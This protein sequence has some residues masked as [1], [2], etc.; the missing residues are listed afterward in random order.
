M[1]RS[2]VELRFGKRGGQTPQ[3]SGNELTVEAVLEVWDLP[4]RETIQ[5]TFEE[6]RAHRA[7]LE[8]FVDELLDEI[9]K[10]TQSVAGRERELAENQR[11]IEARQ[12]ELAQQRQENELIRQALQGQDA[13]LAALLEKFEAVRGELNDAR[14]KQ[15]AN[16]DSQ[17]EALL[18]RLQ[19]ERDDLKQ[20]LDV[21]RDELA[22]RADVTETLTAT[23]SE[24]A[25][26]RAE[27]IQ[28]QHELESARNS[29]SSRIELEQERVALETELEMVRR[30][31][32][33]LTETMAEQKD[34]F[35][36][37]QAAWSAEL[38]K[39]R[40]LLETQSTMLARGMSDSKL[41]AAS[42]VQ[43]AS[44]G[45]GKSQ[46]SGEADSPVVD[47]IMAQFAKLQ[48]DVSERRKRKN[49]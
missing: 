2:S 11:Q 33:D 29:D 18:A 3:T 31:A 13:H 10:L 41:P 22:R 8:D 20:R 34:Q 12:Q 49:Q 26:A 9:E 5:K 19:F 46:S 16:D 28:L 23:Q 42:P 47:S 43:A 32:A 7:G 6:F 40:Q 35:S 24:L 37:Q 48:K 36:Q 30:R 25:Q 17:S 44:Q 27:I 39:L 21:C 38:K 1:P 45:K 15:G 4:G 14:E